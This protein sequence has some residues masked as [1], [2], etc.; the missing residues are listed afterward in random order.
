MR[1]NLT[2]NGRRFLCRDYKPDMH[3][4]RNCL[5]VNKPRLMYAII[6]ISADK[7]RC[8]SYRTSLGNIVNEVQNL[9]DRSWVDISREVM[10]N[11]EHD[12]EM[13]GVKTIILC[14]WADQHNIRDSKF[15]PTHPGRCC[16]STS[17]H[18]SKLLEL[19]NTKIHD[20]NSYIN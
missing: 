19:S 12:K 7:M 18:R 20:A 3:L 11:S 15:V 14:H 1:K 2:V 8:I 5:M 16:T 17:S 4:I 13:A 9:S 6:E 10:E